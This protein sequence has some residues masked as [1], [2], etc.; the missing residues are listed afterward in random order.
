[1]IEVPLDDPGAASFLHREPLEEAA[2]PRF[3]GHPRGREL[4]GRRLR[5]H[6]ERLRHRRQRVARGQPR[7]RFFASR[8]RSRASAALAARSATAAGTPPPSRGTARSSSSA[9]SRAVAPRRVRATDPD[10]KK[11]WFFYDSSD[12]SKLGQFVLPRPQT[13][14]ENLH[15]PQLQHRADEQALRARGRQLPGRHQRRRFHR[16]GERRGSRLRRPGAAPRGSVSR[17]AG[18]LG[19]DWSTCTG[20]TAVSTSPTS[21]AG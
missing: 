6:V 9:G 17:P 2:Q 14:T 1:M 21:R 20:T 16:P 10:V 13:A 7:T 15:D 18:R 11:S 8:L 19:E 12:G 4:G 3:G 5:A